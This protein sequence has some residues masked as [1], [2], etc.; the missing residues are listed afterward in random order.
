MQHYYFCISQRIMTNLTPAGLQ[1]RNIG[2]GSGRFF[3]RLDWQRL[4]CSSPLP[5]DEHLVII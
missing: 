2:S 3:H 4:R 1:A 5:N